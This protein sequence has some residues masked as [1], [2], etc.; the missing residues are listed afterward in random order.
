MSPTEKTYITAQT[1][2][3][4]PHVLI[5]AI[6]YVIVDLKAAKRVRHKSS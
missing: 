4:K 5:T 1:S 2:N 3:S 6:V